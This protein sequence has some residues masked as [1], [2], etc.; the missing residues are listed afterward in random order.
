MTT[1]ARLA[2]LIGPDIPE[3]S[4]AYKLASLR[5]ELREV[6]AVRKPFRDT[7][8]QEEIEEALQRLIGSTSRK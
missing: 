8:R 1:K 5:A 2:E 4:L 3:T 7:V 6:K